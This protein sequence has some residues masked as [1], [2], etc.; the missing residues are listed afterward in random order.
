VRYSIEGAT[1]QD[2]LLNVRR[3]S[4]SFGKNKVLDNVSFSVGRGEIVALLGHNGSGKSTLVKILAGAYSLDAGDIKQGEFGDVELHFIHQT[5][6]LVPGLTVAENLDLGL[7]HPWWGLMPVRRAE[8]RRRIQNMLTKFGV[9]FSPDAIVAGL[10]AADR[11]IVAIVRALAGW[12]D[13]NHVLVLD[14]PTATLHGE[15]IDRLKGAVR[16]VA[17]QGAGV[18]YITHRLA[19][20]EELADRAIVLK[21]GV[22]I[23]EELRGAFTHDSLVRAIA[24][25]DAQTRSRRASPRRSAL[26]E[27]RGLAGASLQSATFHA[28]EG[29]ILGVSGL[30]GSGMERLNGAVFGAFPTS[31]GVVLVG[32]ALVALGSPRSAIAA[33]VAYV[34]ADRRARASV[35]HFSA[36]ENLT[37]ARM[38]DIRRPWGAIDRA[39][40]RQEALT[41]MDQLRVTPRGQIEQAF[42]VFSG[43]NQQKIVLAKWLRMQPRVFLIDEPTQGVDAGAQAEIYELLVK[44]ARAGAAVVIASSDTKELAHICDRALVMRDGVV[45]SELSG[46]DISEPALIS[47]VIDDASDI[48]GDRGVKP[49]QHV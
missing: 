10:T 33:G 4:K 43:G 8:E 49:L 36:R 46:A 34:P 42:D 9:K 38:R 45:G 29:E 40:E 22:K 23:L 31:A 44:A 28:R 3:V 20:A 17:A 12:R 47:A 27:V 26:L 32:G 18:I 48:C 14:E 1:M 39:R 30:V 16:T 5:L 41:W 11:T 6:G 21:N 19:E 24:G 25:V 13:G 2:I 7:S 35:G 37:L 15:E